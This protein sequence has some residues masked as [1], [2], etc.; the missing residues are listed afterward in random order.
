MGVNSYYFSLRQRQ[1]CWL[2]ATSQANFCCSYAAYFRGTL[3][4]VM[5]WNQGKETLCWLPTEIEVN[6]KVTERIFFERDSNKPSQVWK[7]FW[8]KANNER[9]LRCVWISFRYLVVKNS[10]E[11]ERLVKNFTFLFNFCIYNIAYFISWIGSS[12]VRNTYANLL[13]K[14]KYMSN[15]EV[16]RWEQCYKIK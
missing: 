9:L 1:H 7:T 6:T 14:M 10:S 15:L 11:M 4:M 5:S 13:R 3:M 12:K 16:K 8:I 2:P